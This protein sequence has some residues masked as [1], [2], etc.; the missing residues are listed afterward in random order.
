MERR[1]GRVSDELAKIEKVFIKRAK[2]HG[3]LKQLADDILLLKK[4]R[5][6]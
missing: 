5:W 6:I 1:I 2:K 3:E 4:M